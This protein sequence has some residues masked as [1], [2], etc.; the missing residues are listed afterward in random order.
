MDLTLSESEL[1]FQAEARE[2][3]AANVPAEPLPS[4]DTEE[5]FAAHREWEARLAEA[6]WSVVS[7]PEEYGGRGASL[8]EWVIFEEEYYRA[9]APGTGLAERHL[10]AGAD[11]LRPRDEG[12]AGPLPPGDGH[13]RAGL[14]AGLV[15]AGGRVRPGLAEVDRPARRRPRRLGAQRPEDLVVAG[16]LRPLGLRALPL[17]PR[18][19]AARGADVLPV[20]AG[21][22]RR[23]RP[24]DR[25]ARRRGGLRRDLLR[26]RVRPRLRRPRRP[27]RRVAG[28]DEHRRQRARPLPAL[29]RPVLR[30]RRPA[31]RPLPGAWFRDRRKR[32]FLNHRGLGG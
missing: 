8:V 18:G 13:R 2:W 32:A 6:R 7:W 21:R 22:R 17:R 14:G 30:R 20:P 15:R 25:P 29:P 5:G 27:G 24:P 16:V 28:R 1:A 12:A 4:M 19:A 11:R 10:P 26:G 3:L 31:G 23:H 9:G